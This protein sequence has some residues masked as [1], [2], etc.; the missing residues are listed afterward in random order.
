MRIPESHPRYESLV[1]REKMVNAVKDNIIVQEGLIAHGRGEAYDYIM[2]EKTKKWAIQAI[3]ASAV[4][5]MNASYPVISVNGNAAA[6]A[7]KELVELSKIIPAKLEVNLFHRSPIRIRK[8]CDYLRSMGATEVLGE[9]AEKLIEGIEHSRS[10]SSPEGIIKADVVF[11]PLEDGDRAKAL[12]AIGKKVIC[13]DLNP[14]SRTAITS[15]ITIV[16]NIT[17]AIPLLTEEIKKIKS[18]TEKELEEA[19]AFAT[20]YSNRDVLKEAVE[21]IIEYL[22]EFNPVRSDTANI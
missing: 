5:L 6:L 1:T 12:K 4:T 8:I 16:D 13:I 2:G 15:D 20:E 7:G 10:Y 14:L 19:N 9:D 11:V 21:G 22:G 3:K 18:G 17:R